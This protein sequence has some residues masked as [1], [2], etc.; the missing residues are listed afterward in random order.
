[1][2]VE[3][4]PIPRKRKEATT[5]KCGTVTPGGTTFFHLKNDGWG[6]GVLTGNNYDGRVGLYIVLLRPQAQHKWHAYGMPKLSTSHTLYLGYLAFALPSL[7]LYGG[8]IGA[9]SDFPSS[10]GGADVTTVTDSAFTTYGSSKP[11]HVY[12]YIYHAWRRM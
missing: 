2:Y 7:S 4:T 8:S 10:R 11:I 12:T 6:K 5:Q 1:M 9:D 3:A